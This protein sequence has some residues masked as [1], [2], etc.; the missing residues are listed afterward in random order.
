MP[1]SHMPDKANPKAEGVF[2]LTDMEKSFIQP[3]EEEGR[4]DFTV[5]MAVSKCMA[6]GNFR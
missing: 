3:R 5:C 6:D 4:G 1:D 2:C